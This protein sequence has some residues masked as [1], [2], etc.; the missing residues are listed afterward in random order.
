MKK[1]LELK[2][3]YW[4]VRF[5]DFGGIGKIRVKKG[6]AEKDVRVKAARIF[7]PRPILT[8]YKVTKESYYGPLRFK[9]RE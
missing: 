8:L 3:D 5:S 2:S 4:F 9:G 1:K 7:S 6:T